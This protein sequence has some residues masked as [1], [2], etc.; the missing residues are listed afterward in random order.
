MEDLINAFLEACVTEAR[1]VALL[2]ETL[3]CERDALLG[4][5]AVQLE[6]LGRSKSE[7]LTELHAL[8]QVRSAL[9][10][11]L[12]LTDQERLN[13]WLADKPQ[14]LAAWEQLAGALMRSQALNRVNGELL[15]RRMDFV[16]QALSVLKAAASATLSYGR[17]GTQP[18][19]LTGGRHLGS[20]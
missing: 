11:S 16:D 12:G 4:G 8:G 19:G 9:M 18:A 3:E 1:C 14:A 2:S 5:D 17:D 6:A 15:Q 13:A 10:R 20:A 7:T